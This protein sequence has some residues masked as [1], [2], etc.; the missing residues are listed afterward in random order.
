MM[1]KNLIFATLS[2]ATA[3]LAAGCAHAVADNSK[4]DNNKVGNS[5]T[6]DLKKVNNKTKLMLV[7]NGDSKTFDW[8]EAELSDPKALEKALAEVPADKREQIKQMLTQMKTDHSLQFVVEG[9]DQVIVTDLSDSGKV[10]TNKKVVI[11]KLNGADGTDFSLLK[12]LLV[13]AK[14]SKAQLQELQKLLDSKY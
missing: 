9:D 4:I 3:L 11:H 14:L 8:T 13:D 7:T 6:I 2:L 10:R 5:E 1:K 12:S